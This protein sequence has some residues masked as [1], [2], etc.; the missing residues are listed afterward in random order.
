MASQNSEQTGKLRDL[1]LSHQHTGAVTNSNND[2][3][4]L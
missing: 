2:Q 1:E 3:F 4:S